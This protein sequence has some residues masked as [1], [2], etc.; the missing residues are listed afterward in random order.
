MSVKD[1]LLHYAENL[2]TAIFTSVATVVTGVS[3]VMDWIPNDF[4]ATTAT[5]IGM[6]LS[7]VLIYTHWRKGRAEYKKTMLEAD[8]LKAELAEMRRNQSS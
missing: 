4:L 8:I 6:M 5:I 7:L 2:K 3:G 1:N